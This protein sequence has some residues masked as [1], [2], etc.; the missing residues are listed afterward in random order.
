MFRGLSKTIPAD[1]A[2]D[3]AKIRFNSNSFMKNN[4]RETGNFLELEGS[5]KGSPSRQLLTL[6]EFIN[7]LKQSDQFKNTSLASSNR[8]S[9]KNNGSRI[10]KFRI[11]ATVNGL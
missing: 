8:V 9:S 10:L 6:R 5:V 7:G 2:L 4:K 3:S 11:T 1:I